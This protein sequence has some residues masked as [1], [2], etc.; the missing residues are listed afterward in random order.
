MNRNLTYHNSELLER[1][2]AGDNAAFT[3][4]FNQYW[5]NI[6]SVA[7]VLTKSEAM[8][9]DVVQEI[10]LKI[11]NKRQELTAVTRFD[12]YLF[13]LARNHIFSDFKKLRIRKEHAERLQHYFSGYEFT[14]EDQLME[15]EVSAILEAAVAGL[16]AQQQQVYRLN[17]EQ[18]LTYEQIAEELGIS[19]HTVRNHMVRA[20]KHIREYLLP[21]NTNLIWLAA[22][23]R[24]FL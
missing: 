16:S 4:L 23:L 13:I 21:Y 20:L 19:V 3:E 14:P 1:V 22:L 8:A 9:E 24:A 10:F 5:D 17:R 7:L 11:W 18:G 6:Y 12:N 15:K 2:A